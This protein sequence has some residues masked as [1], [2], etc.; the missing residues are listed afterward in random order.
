MQGGQ[1][2]YA[3]YAGQAEYA[4]EDSCSSDAHLWSPLD[5]AS[6]EV[7]NSVPAKYCAVWIAN[8]GYERPAIRPCRHRE[9]Q[10]HLRSSW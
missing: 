10:E 7:L 4:H 9:Q 8:S 3:E 1:A 5:M 6:V 2:E